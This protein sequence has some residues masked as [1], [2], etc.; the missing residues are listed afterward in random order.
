[1][2]LPYLGPMAINNSGSIVFE[3]GFA[4]GIVNLLRHPV[5]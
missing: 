4:L 3:C 2:Q 1:M 5:F